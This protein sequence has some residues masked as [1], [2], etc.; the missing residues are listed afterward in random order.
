MNIFLYPLMEEM[1]EL[2]QGVD[3][4]DSHLKCRFNLH[5]ASAWHARGGRG[6]GDQHWQQWSSGVDAAEV[7]HAGGITL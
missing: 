6:V 3:V 5:S 7:G 2:W 1:K 4:Y